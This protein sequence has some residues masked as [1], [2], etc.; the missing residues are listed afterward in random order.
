MLSVADVKAKAGRGPGRDGG[1]RNGGRGIDRLVKEEVVGDGRWRESGRRAEVGSL[2]RLG[3]LFLDDF[4][5]ALDD[6]TGAR[7]GRGGTG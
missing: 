1:N 4:Y 6:G 3:D 2:E 7:L 5:L